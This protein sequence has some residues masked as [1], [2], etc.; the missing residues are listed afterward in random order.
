MKCH[1]SNNSHKYILTPWNWV[2]SKFCQMNK[3]LS[4][5]NLKLHPQNSNNF[6]IYFLFLTAKTTNSNYRSND[7]S[8]FPF[9]N[10]KIDNCVKLLPK[11][12][13]KTFWFFSLHRESLECLY[14]PLRLARSDGLI[15][16]ESL[17]GKSKMNLLSLAFVPSLFLPFFF[18][19][20]FK[21]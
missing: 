2:R 19:S 18:L 12:R 8:S 1:K 13:N 17:I 10:N 4:F 11:V 14:F 15:L 20:R 5:I 16:Y 9:Q 7:M 21:E 3:K 6:N